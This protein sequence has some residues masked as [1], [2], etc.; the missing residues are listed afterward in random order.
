MIS[1]PFDYHNLAAAGFLSP[2]GQCKPFDSSADGYC[3]GEGVAVVVLKRLS[4]AIKDGDNILGVISGSAVNQ[5]HNDSLIT[6]PHSGSQSALYRDVL[7]LTGLQPE[8][9]T[10]VEAHGT[11]TGVGDPIEVRSIR[12]VFGGPQRDSVLH[13]ASIKGNIGHTEG[14][15]GVAG[16]IKVLLMMR[17]KLI[18]M[19]ASHNITNPKIASLSQ[20]RMAIP[21]K[22]LSWD[23]PFLAACV[24]SYGAAGS[25]SALVVVDK[26]SIPTTTCPNLSKFSR[27]PMIISANSAYSLAAYSRKLLDWMQKH[28]EKTRP[29][30]LASLT[31]HLADRANHALPHILSTTVS[32]VHDLE[33]TLEAAAKSQSPSSVA[34]ITAAESP[35]P[36]ILVFGGQESEFIG[37]SRDVYQSSKIFREHLDICNDLF[38]AN[39]LESFLPHIFDHEPMPNLVTLHTALFAVQYASAK[40]WMDCGLRVSAV[41]G[42]SFGH[43]TALCISGVLSLPDA[44]T[45]V[46][47]RAS[48][49]VKHWGDE[50]GSM[51]F[52]QADRRTVVQ[53]LQALEAQDKNHYAEIACCNGR[54]SHV[55]VG[56]SSS[57]SALEQYLAKTAFPRDSVR[58]KKLQVTHGFHSKFTE[59][60]LIHLGELAKTLSWRS[61]SIHLE[62]C[63]EDRSVSEPDFGTIAEHTRRPV[64]FQQA[65]ER[66]AERY[67]QGATWVEVGRGSS[68]INLAKGSVPN[69][70]GHSFLSPLLT[71]SD[72][73]GSLTNVTL[74]LW[75]AGY[76]VQ[77]WPFHR[78]QKLDYGPLLSLPPYQFEKT[79]HWLPFTGNRFEKGAAEPL[80]E[81]AR[82]GETHKIL[83]FLRF[84]DSAGREAVFR[85]EP[86]AERFKTMLGGHVMAGQ[87]LC[88]ASLYYELVSRAAMS[89]EQDAGAS[90]QVPTVYDLVMKS[91]IG[92]DTNVEI[93]L[94]LKRLDDGLSSSWNFSITTTQATGVG[95]LA[96]PF[97]VSTGKVCLKKRDDP[98]T[99]K[100]FKRYESLTGSRR[101]EEVLGH[102]DAETMQGG[103]IYRAFTT[104]VYYGPGFRG[105]RQIASLGRE[106]AGKVVITPARDGPDDQRLCD[107]PMTDSFMQ[108][109]GFLVNYFNNPSLEEVFVCGKIDHIE[110]GGS[111][112][113][114]AKEWIVYATTTEGGETDVSADAYVFEAGSKKMVMA[115]F[116]LR[117]NRMPQALLGRMLRSVN[118]AGTTGCQSTESHVAAVPGHGPTS[119]PAQ[120]A[121]KRPSRTKRLELFRLMSDITDVPLEDIKDKS[122]LDELGIDSLMAT[123]VLNNIRSVLGL[124]IDLTSFLFFADV[125]A[126]AAHI[127]EKLGVGGGQDDGS[128]R[129]PTPAA[130]WD[131]LSTR[132]SSPEPISVNGY[133]TVKK[134]SRATSQFASTTADRT[135]PPPPKNIER[136][137]VTSAAGAFQ[138]VRFRYDQLA[139]GTR[140]L[141]FWSQAY[142]HQARLVL[143]YVM[144][145][146]AELG[147]DLKKLS[148]G[149]DIPQVRGV[150]DRHTRLIR[151]L[152][153]VL[154]HGKLI[155]PSTDQSFARTDTPADPA[156]AESIY[157]EIIELYPQHA[158]V[159]K[160]VRIVG[161][162]LAAC[163]TGR[164]DG[165]QTVFGNKEAKKTLEHIYEFWPLFRTPTLVLGDFLTKA[166]TMATGSGKFK[167]LEVGAGTGGTTR[168]L[169][170]HLKSHGIPFEYVF[171]DVSSSLVAAARQQFR[172]AEDMSFE[173]L[174]IEQKPKPEHEA[175]F[176]CVIA[177]NTIHATRDL[178]QSL[179]NLRAMVRD[180]GALVLVEITRQVF[181]LDLVFG[182]FE[183]W[184]LFEDGR[185]HA[186]IDE[187]QWGS[188]MRAAG[189]DEVFWS[190]GASPE[191][192]T[193]RAIG[194]FTSS[195]KTVVRTASP[196]KAALETVVYK[197]MGNLE[198]HADVYYPAGGDLPEGKMPVGTF[199]TEPE[200]PMCFPASRLT[201]FVHPALMIHGGSHIMFTRKDVRPPQTRLL[202]ERGFIPVALDHRLC[203]EVSLSEGPMTDVCDA[204]E[205][206]RNTLPSLHFKRRG[207]QIDGERVVVVGWSSGGQLAMST[208]WTAPQRGLR[209]PEAILAFYCPTNYEDEWWTRPIQPVGAED[210][211]LQ[212]DVLE[213]VQDEPITNY[214]LVGAWEPL[215]DPRILTD[216][217]CRIVLHINWKAQTLPVITGGLPSRKKAS[218]SPDG[219]DW[220][221]LAQPS[222]EQIRAVSPMAHIQAGSYKTP[223]F[224][225]HGT[226]DDLI[227]WQQSQ[228]TYEVMIQKGIPA[229]LALVEGAPHITDLS[230]NPDSKGWQAALRGYDF[231]CSYVF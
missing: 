70:S 66:L 6:V 111:F 166:F 44:A 64:F 131:M 191:S 155:F 54:K 186:L 52:L 109:A 198:I 73:Q 180:D 187:E 38:V 16:L 39:G 79:R 99:L 103:H 87:G 150:L 121:L 218:E 7:G 152:L 94:K 42:H 140:A 193:V 223:T 50:P 56:S 93:I 72:A 113:P 194:A 205:W 138:D 21:R 53:A 68:A 201:H 9:V 188:R 143:A 211:G 49:M 55:V 129:V 85:I 135:V 123:E 61:P 13:F 179:R 125:G 207:L 24:N 3:R 84:N 213:A 162:N 77:Y 35:K 97:E 219:R 169:L 204:L 145:A 126:L 88:P 69:T 92:R 28:V 230:S 231:I 226:A 19:Q 15:A 4:D 106:A 51:V 8:S 224:L 212:Y 144:E 74:D 60:M 189:F 36:I 23:A 62:T 115:I 18:P 160:L 174:D 2:T 10:Y 156:D 81:I 67:S 22:V 78:S 220:N 114:D 43:L 108:F 116:G 142:P 216:A 225:I 122:T 210:T 173:V 5:N 45:L 221:A 20:D 195:H 185:S 96:D 141:Q 146:F 30:I 133:T 190:D 89:L 57:I 46:A 65:I 163:L 127:D 158:S 137:T 27:W 157:H 71:T 167:I 217:R 41:V 182:Q 147:C 215:S 14:T 183:G 98:Q 86:N 172:D 151:Q 110:I 63:D 33:S 124:T 200:S 164:T 171:T 118:K 176:H 80:R 102:P 120:V 184:W 159:N 48:L 130:S 178:D 197:R 104:V 58:T 168:Y 25:N 26:P 165:I 101:I 153:R 161:S 11:G 175:A 136:P 76:A 17:H 209:P 228:G 154:E 112:N 199:Q 170:S 29:D 192:K 90:T 82:E 105:I 32:S 119:T 222:L 149:D 132:S 75:R 31:F 208:A 203:P 128:D 37:L 139:E 91:P 40:A 34:S 117:F 83:E 1:S 177:T 148:P 47:G 214:G 107:T 59:P 196:V 206:S 229:E 134:D 202:L 181:W 12:D 95:H 227:P 100:E